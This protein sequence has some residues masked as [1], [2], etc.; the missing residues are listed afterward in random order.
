MRILIV[1]SIVS[2]AIEVGT[3]SPEKRK[4]AWI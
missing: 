3:A 2:I 1:A 4:L